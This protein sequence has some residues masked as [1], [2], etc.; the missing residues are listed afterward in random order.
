[1]K[2]SYRK[3]LANHPDPESCGVAREVAIEALT[4]ACA[5]EVLSP[6]IGRSGAP[7]L[8]TE[9]EGN[10]AEGAIASPLRD[11]RGRRPSTCAE[12]PR[13]RTG[14][15]HGRLAQM[16]SMAASERPTVAHRW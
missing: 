9:A 12:T 10:I 1:M 3:E 11:R 15:S 2:E 14:R 13:A 16:V 7:T 5:G 8:L 6:E 4:G